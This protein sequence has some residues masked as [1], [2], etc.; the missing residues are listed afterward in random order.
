MLHF[1]RD[2]VRQPHLV[3]FDGGVAQPA[4]AGVRVRNALPVLLVV[5][6]TLVAVLV[7]IVDTT[8]AWSP[9]AAATSAVVLAAHALLTH[10][11]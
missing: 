1:D 3:A 9:Y 8:P 5:A 6:A 10:R 11:A 4:T 7:D 2:A